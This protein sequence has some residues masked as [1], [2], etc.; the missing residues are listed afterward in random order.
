M[1]PKQWYRNGWLSLSYTS[2]T[3]MDGY[4]PLSGGSRG[5]GRKICHHIAVVLGVNCTLP[6]EVRTRSSKAAIFMFDS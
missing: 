2:K 5:I 4:R 6:A 3:V 1:E